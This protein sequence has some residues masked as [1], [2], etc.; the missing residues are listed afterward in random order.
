MVH[1]LYRSVK[2]LTEITYKIRRT[3]HYTVRL[4]KAL[5]DLSGLKIINSKALD[6]TNI[7]P[8]VDDSHN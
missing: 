7:N 4:L 2:E 8:V 6:L 5:V 3:S 1:F